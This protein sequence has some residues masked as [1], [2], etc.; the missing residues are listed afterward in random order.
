[1]TA[2][3]DDTVT[4]P[5]LFTRKER[6]GAVEF[7]PAT[8]TVT[9]SE[10]VAPLIPVQ[11]TT[12][13]FVTVEEPVFPGAVR[14]SEPPV[15]DLGPVHAF[16]ALQSADERFAVVHISEIG[17]PAEPRASVSAPFTLSSTVG[18]ERL[19]VALLKFTQPMFTSPQA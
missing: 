1:V 5:V 12:Y 14:D 3:P 13:V 17:P 10:T 9:V 2:V 16:V 6:N 15:E 11:V 7:K 4:E 8:V 18:F 19:R